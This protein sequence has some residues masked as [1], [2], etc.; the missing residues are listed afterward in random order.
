MCNY[1]HWL[2]P[3]TLVLLLN[4]CF[5]IMALADGLTVIHCFVTNVQSH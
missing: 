4:H 3:Y 2:E 5:A 1:A